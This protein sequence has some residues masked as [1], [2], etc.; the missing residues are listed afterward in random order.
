[1]NAIDAD[2]SILGAA[3]LDDEERFGAAALLLEEQSML[4]AEKLVL[5]SRAA[6]AVSCSA[7]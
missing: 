7:G 5:E 3:I 4:S 6:C 2:F 1:M